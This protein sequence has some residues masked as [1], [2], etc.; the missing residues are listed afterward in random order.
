MYNANSQIF[1][2]NVKVNSQAPIVKVSQVCLIIVKDAYL[3]KK[4]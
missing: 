1:D 4:L 2:A 3:L